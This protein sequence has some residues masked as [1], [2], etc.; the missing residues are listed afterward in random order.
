ML[1]S[2]VLESSNNFTRQVTLLCC[3][4]SDACRHTS[5]EDVVEVLPTNLA[6]DLQELALEILEDGSLEDGADQKPKQLG[7]L[8]V[9]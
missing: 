5:L 3:T 8:L 1:C 6:K 4:T 7:N 9:Q 2:D